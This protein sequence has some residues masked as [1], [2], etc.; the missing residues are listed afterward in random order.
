MFKELNELAEGA[1]SITLAIKASDADGL[2][3]ITV[4]P[5]V[6]KDTDV[7]LRQPL[8]LRGTPEELDE[9]FLDA[10]AKFG[11]TRQTLADQVEATAQVLEAARE[12]SAA[13]SAGAAAK[14]TKSTTSKVGGAT[15]KVPAGPNDAESDEDGEPKGAREAESGAAAA[16]VGETGSFN[17]F[18]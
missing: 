14:A 11:T 6:E 2:M 1:E 12:A 3:R 10:L 8:V 17:L 18:D 9:G 7:A 13:Q 5:R 4:L 16:P 15:P